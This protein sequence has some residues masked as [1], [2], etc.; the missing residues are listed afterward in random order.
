MSAERARLSTG[1]GDGACF[2]C[3]D[4]EDTDW[5]RWTDSAQEGLLC[6]DCVEMQQ[7]MY[8]TGSGYHL[9]TVV[10]RS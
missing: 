7:A 10:R 6:P 1:G 9:V 4:T 8:S 3:G 5:W 2:A